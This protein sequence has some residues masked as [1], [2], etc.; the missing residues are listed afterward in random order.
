[1]AGVPK[2]TASV[3]AQ[4]PRAEASADHDVW[5]RA[6]VERAIVEADDPDARWVTQEE[7]ERD[8]ARQRASIAKASA[9]QS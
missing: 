3:P 6:E 7:A 4:R 8:W 9:A 1:M 2:P 5:F